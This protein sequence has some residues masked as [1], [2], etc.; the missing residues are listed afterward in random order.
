MPQSGYCKFVYFSYVFWILGTAWGQN[1][2]HAFKLKQSIG[3][4]ATYSP[5]SHP[6]LIGEAEQRKIV[7]GG[8]EYTRQIFENQ[9]FSVDYKAEVAPYF[10]ES[11]PT[12]V[13][14]ESTAFGYTMTTPLPAPVRV[15][16]KDHIPVGND[17]IAPNTC[18][19]VY[20][21]YG[22]NE[23]TRGMAFSPLG[24]RALFLPRYRLQPSF[25][26]DVGGIIS[27]RALPVDGA[28]KFNYQFSF[29]P[30]VQFRL[31]PQA[32]LRVEY[33]FRHIS[34]ANSGVINP[35]IDQ[36]VFRSSLSH[37]W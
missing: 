33:I 29:G 34:N 32:S 15:I 30:G 26:M 19:P 22:A 2:V 6:L 21:V 13:A 9:H 4:N 5:N 31:S 27:S 10:Q 1:D 23:V 25:A 11:D 35:G 24:A 12:A 18:V 16:R 14:Y 20:L 3:I 7:T 8:I 17:C 36:A 37:S 28:A